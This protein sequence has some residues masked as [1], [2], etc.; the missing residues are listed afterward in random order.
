M[1]QQVLVLHAGES[2][3]IPANSTILSLIVSGGAEVSSTCDNLPEPTSYKCWVFQWEDIDDDAYNDAFFTKIQIGTTDYSLVGIGV[4][5][6]NS[7]DEGSHYIA[8]ALPFITP[9]GLVTA[10]SWGGG[11][12]AS[13]KCVAISIPE[14]LGAPTLFWQNTNPGGSTQYSAFFGV[15]N[16]DCTSCGDV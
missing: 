12:D 4:A 7:Y 10:I 15:E 1:G 9:A 16:A 8:N 3:V 6:T 13:T 2:A 11:A 14:E 5:G